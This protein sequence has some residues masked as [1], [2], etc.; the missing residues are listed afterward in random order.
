MGKVGFYYFAFSFGIHGITARKGFAFV[1]G[2]TE[3]ML[4]V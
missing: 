4:A 2:L 3:F 1:K